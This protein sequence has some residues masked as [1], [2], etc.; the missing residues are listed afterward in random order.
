MAGNTAVGIGAS[1][2]PFGSIAY[3]VGRLIYSISNNTEGHQ[4]RIDKLTFSQ[5]NQNYLR[6]QVIPPGSSYKGIL[7]LGFEND[8]QQGDEIILSV[9]TGN[10]TQA[11][12]FICNKP[13]LD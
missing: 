4:K 11:F 2:I 3:S 7:K 8:L 1:F 13:A 6:Q 9:V 5:L 12:N 10:E